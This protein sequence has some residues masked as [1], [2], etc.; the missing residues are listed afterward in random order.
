VNNGGSTVTSSTP[1]DIDAACGHDITPAALTRVNILFLLDKSGSMGD[2]PNGGWAH[3]AIR[4]D[5]VVT[6]LDA[7]FNDQNSTGIYASLS[8]LPAD[9]SIASACKETSYSGGSSSIKVPLTLLNDAGRKKFLSILCDPSLPQTPPCIVPAG[10]TPT[11]PALQGTIDYMKSLPVTDPPSKNVIVFLTDGEPGFGYQA[12]PLVG[13]Y[14]CDDL[15]NSACLAACS[16][17]TDATCLSAGIDPPCS[18]PQAEVDAVATVI[19]G[20]PPKSIYL[21]GVGDLSQGTMDEWATASGNAALALQNVTDPAQAASL[22]KTALE[23]IRSSSIPCTIPVPKSTTG[24]AVDYTKVNVDYF[25]GSNQDTPLYKDLN[26]TSTTHLGWHYDN[27]AAPTQIVLCASACSQIQADPNG[28]I[29]TVLGC[30][31]RIS[32]L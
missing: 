17:L 16:G 13:L 9:G 32:I 15:S 10:G 12:S 18:T 19:Q 26:C 28:K 24:V 11:R 2:D 3:A 20:A 8:F 31:T 21:I 25:N 6:T 29:Q 27:D 14:S 23:S 30:D 4:W 5:P 22:L 1:V 7:F